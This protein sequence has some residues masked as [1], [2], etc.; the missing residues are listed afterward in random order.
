L[1]NAQSPLSAKDVLRCRSIRSKDNAKP[2]AAVV[3]IRFNAIPPEHPAMKIPV[4]VA[5]A[6]QSAVHAGAEIGTT[7]CW[8]STQIVGARILT[9]LPH[10]ARFSCGA[11]AVVFMSAA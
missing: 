8:H 6:A 10:V 9:P 11:R 3:G 4:V 5:T 1:Q 7:V 2:Y